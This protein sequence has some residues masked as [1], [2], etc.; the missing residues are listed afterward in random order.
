MLQQVARHRSGMPQNRSALFWTP[1][2]DR[3]IGNAL[4]GRV[5]WRHGVG[6]DSFADE[7]IGARGGRCPYD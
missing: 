5:D 3:L 7:D 1:E 2:V 4:E 6:F